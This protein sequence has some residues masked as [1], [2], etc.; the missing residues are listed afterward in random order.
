MKYYRYLKEIEEEAQETDANYFITYAFSGTLMM[1][2]IIP[3][4][5]STRNMNSR[6][7]GFIRQ[8][9]MV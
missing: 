6:L 5:H 7:V 4:T 2:A 3:L 9:M 8:L 1:E